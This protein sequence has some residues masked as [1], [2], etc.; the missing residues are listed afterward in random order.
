MT[1]SV[2]DQI[3]DAKALFVETAPK[4]LNSID[5]LGQGK[6]ALVQANREFGFA[7]SDEEIDYLTDAFN[8][9]GRN[10]HDIELMMFAQANSEHCRHKIF[11]AQWTIDGEKQPLS[12]FQMIKNTYKESPTDV[13]S[14]YKDNASVIVGYDTMR[15]YP[16]ADDNGQYV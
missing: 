9:L 2:F 10:P 13:L 3:D 8:K 14:A 16:K 11:N 4:P 6:E 12:L 15:F 7:L 1:E 5:I